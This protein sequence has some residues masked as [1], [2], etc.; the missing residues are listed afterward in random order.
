MDFKDEII[1]K[2]EAIEF[3][4][5]EIK[6]L[7]YNV[8]VKIENCAAP[9]D[10]WCA[11]NDALFAEIEKKLNEAE[12]NNQ[13]RICGQRFVERYSLIIHNMEHLRVIIN[14]RI[15]QCH[16][17]SQYYTNL[18][19][20][21]KHMTSHDKNK[22]RLKTK[23]NHECEICG[24]ILPYKRWHEHVKYKH[25]KE[26]YECSKCLIKF[27]S[28]IYLR[29]HKKYV[30]DGVKAEW[31]HRTSNNV[32]NKE[33]CNICDKVFTNRKSLTTHIRNCHSEPHQCIICKS[34][35]KSKSYLM[36]HMIRVH[37]NSGNVHKCEI[38]GKKF[39]SLRY[40]KIH[41]K[42]SHMNSKKVIKKEQ[43]SSEEL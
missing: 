37:D 21:K 42:N 11:R 20:L 31:R 34:I 30:H 10:I 29:R 5:E 19:N 7:D 24:I 23:M 13:C 28:P 6:L 1:I 12:K 41:I 18:N 33:P 36:T 43:D 4:E 15:F 22:K 17:C 8:S 14:N 38:C 26:K 9:D 40:V 32:L 3:E 27:K 2:E 35:L 39:K 25:N 16:I